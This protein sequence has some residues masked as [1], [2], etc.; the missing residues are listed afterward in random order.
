VIF[1]IIYF[2]QKLDNSIVASAGHAKLGHILGA[3]LAKAHDSL[4]QAQAQVECG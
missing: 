3:L 4:V 1:Y 2:F